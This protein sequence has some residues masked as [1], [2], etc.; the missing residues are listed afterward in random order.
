MQTLLRLSLLAAA[1]TCAVAIS[2]AQAPPAHRIQ[3][4]TTK[5]TAEFFDTKTGQKFTP[6]GNNYVRLAEMK[7]LTEPT[8]ML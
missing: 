6:R 2:H 8:S 4:R 1:V 5:G 7:K 3:V